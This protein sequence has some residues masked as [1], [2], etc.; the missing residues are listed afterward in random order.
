MFT[1]VNDL[2]VSAAQFAT[3]NVDG[4]VTSNDTCVVSRPSR[5]QWRR[6]RGFAGAGLCLYARIVYWTLNLQYLFSYSTPITTLQ[7][8]HCS[9][10]NCL[11]ALGFLV[12]SQV[13]FNLSISEVIFDLA[14]LWKVRG[15]FAGRLDVVASHPHR[16]FRRPIRC[17]A[18]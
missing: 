1:L 7:S 8:L 2:S 12:T 14:R 3:I 16:L 15:R 17:A 4:T 6:H 5:I 13:Y 9:W 10:Y 11:L 18:M